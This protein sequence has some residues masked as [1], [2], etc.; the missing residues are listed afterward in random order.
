M[1]PGFFFTYR[2]RGNK[3]DIKLKFRSFGPS[4]LILWSGKKDMSSSADYLALGLKDGYLNFQYNLGSGEVII[5]YNITKLD[6]GKWH[7]VRATR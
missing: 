5:V 7:S 3:I 1:N 4:G 2:I 6:D